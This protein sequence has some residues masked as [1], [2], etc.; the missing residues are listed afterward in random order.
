M[1]KHGI[2]R[3]RFS[4]F[5]LLVFNP[6][7]GWHPPPNSTACGSD[8]CVAEE[9]F[10][11]ASFAVGEAPFPPNPNNTQL[12]F[13][14][15]A[16][17]DERYPLPLNATTTPIVNSIKARIMTMWQTAST[18]CP[19]TQ[20]EGHAPPGCDKGTPVEINGVMVWEPW[21]D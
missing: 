9:L 2:T 7:G 12:L 18:S 10:D 4:R 14:V 15:C 5:F 16:D 8:G 1:I 20:C 3:D 11:D 19:E 21:C 17:P 13:D 6:A